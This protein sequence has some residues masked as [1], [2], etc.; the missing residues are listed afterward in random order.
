MH[1]G[2]CYNRRPF[3]HVPRESPM[4]QALYA[5]DELAGF[6][7]ACVKVRPNGITDLQP[8]SVKKKLKD[9]SFAAAVNRDDIARG[10]E[11][12]DV[13]LTDHIQTCIDALRG[14][15]ERLGIQGQAR[16]E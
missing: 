8:K 6:V 11:E 15:A 9:K 5:V 2:L 3:V 16:N 4:A 13:D 14:D 10:V 12:L 7:V 1:G